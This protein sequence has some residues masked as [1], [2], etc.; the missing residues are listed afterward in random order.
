M[1]EFIVFVINAACFTPVIICL[2]KLIR[3]KEN[4]QWRRALLITGVS[5]IG[6]RLF[7]G[8]LSVYTEVLWFDQLGFVSVFWKA[9]TLKVLVYLQSLVIIAVILFLMTRSVKKL[10]LMIYPLPVPD[11][12]DQKPSRKKSTQPPTDYSRERKIVSLVRT[13]S[14]IV[15][16][17]LLAIWPANSWRE[18]MLYFKQV[19]TGQLD[20]IFGKDISFYFFSYPFIQTILNIVITIWLVGLILSGAAYGLAFA[21]VNWDDNSLQLSR[22]KKREVNDSLKIMLLNELSLKMI[23][24]ILLF[25]IDFRLQM[26]SWL[27]SNSGTFIGANYTDIHVRLVVY[28]VLMVLAGV[29]ATI[30]L[31]G[32]LKPTKRLF[33]KLMLLCGPIAGL[34]ITWL[35]AAFI[36]PAIYQQVSVSPS[37]LDKEG[38]YIQNCITSTRQAYSLDKVKVKKFSA[39]ENLTWSDVKSDSGTISNVRL[40]DWHALQQSLKKM[41]E[42]KQYYEFNDVDVDRYTINGT[43]RQVMLSPRE[44]SSD[45]LPA[46][47]QTWVNQKLKYTH[48]YGLC[49]NLANEFDSEGSPKLI[50]ENIPPVS[51]AP[52]VVIK[53][54][55]I[56]FGENTKEYVIVNTTTQEFDYPQ[57]EKNAGCFYAGTGGV[58]LGG[59]LQKLA[60]ALEFDGDKI[61]FSNYLTAS[62]Q[63]IFHREIK[64]RVKKL[65]PFIDYEEDPYL[66]ISNGKLY[67]M[68]DGFTSSGYYPCSES[69]NGC[70]NYIRNSVKAVVDAYS[71][72]TSFYVFDNQDPIIKAWQN[73]FP[74]LFQPSSKMPS[75]LKK[76]VRYPEMIFKIQA[77]MYGTYH[78][79]DVQAF[80]NRE[81]LWTKDKQMH[82][83][84]LEEIEP[85]FLIMK[86]PGETKE[87][88]V[89]ILPFT[90]KGKSNMIGWMASRSDNDH[91]GEMIAFELPK[92][93][94]TVGVS[95]MEAKIDQDPVM[96]QNLSL[97]K[98]KG[99]DVIRGNTLVIPI[100][101]SLLYIEPIFIKADNN[102]MPQLRK[103]ALFYGSKLVWADNFEEALKKLFG[104]ETA[105]IKENSPATNID[106]MATEKIVRTATTTNISESLKAAKKYFDDYRA[107]TSQGK[108]TEAGKALNDLGEALEEL[109]K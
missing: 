89:Q 45:Q 51:H 62:S 104:E 35:L 90:P 97:W 95:Q 2:V 33:T 70:Y 65:T 7:L 78:M 82:A 11:T 16:A 4:I 9:W 105:I 19:P 63:I 24:V 93:K 8:A 60:L 67:W 86:I 53:R 106:N 77:E 1:L 108:Y 27:F 92:G 87:E 43:Y 74:S 46:N 12:D 28:K 49:L 73:I 58:R 55:E 102:P 88:F 69:Y 57:G 56:Y 99:S 54:P 34:F 96:S 61:M 26:F 59:F 48:G 72:Q 3:E 36:F 76:H 98:Q 107:Y 44:M 103:V 66:V 23:P 20:P 29:A 94:Q 42:I 14:I 10:A 81:D 50:V 38:V 31:Y 52:E 109:Q 5:F 30:V 39:D 75:D 68:I 32:A 80:Y 40:W 22:D 83:D 6:L 85:Y 17:L 25:I 101:N 13:A 21:V 79:Q 84:K 100:K 15:A 18:I 47:S 41:Q 37:E 71:G 91:Y 64:D